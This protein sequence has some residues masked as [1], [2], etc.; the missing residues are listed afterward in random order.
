MR[1]ELDNVSVVFDTGV[2]PPV[3]ALDGISLAVA[4]GER[5]GIA[6]PVASGKSTLLAVMAGLVEPTGGRVLHDGKPATRRHPPAARI[7]LAL[8]SPEKCL[9]EKTV[10]DDVAFAPRRLGLEG[11]RLAERVRQALESMGLDPEAFGSRS[12]FSLSTGEQRRV[13]LAGVIAAAPRVLLLDEP[14]AYLDPP[15]R[16]DLL[17]RLLAMNEEQG[18]TMVMVGHDMD[19]MTAFAR[20]LVLVDEGRVAAAGEAAGLLTDV[21]L[22]RR[23]RLREPGTVSLCRLLE[24]AGAGPVPP[25]LDEERLVEML[26]ERAG[27]KAP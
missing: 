12:P 17:Q 25:T 21:G 24:A 14:T 22:L 23:H 6:G 1:I 27:G 3:T 4:P 16:R 7:G 15:S 20:R 2:S 8:Q 19:E 13:A 10:F 9:F 26:A 18:I 11:E 5:L